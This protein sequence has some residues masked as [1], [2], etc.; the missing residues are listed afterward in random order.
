VPLRQLGLHL[1]EL[2]GLLA[3]RAPY[4]Q[5]SSTRSRAGSAGIWTTVMHGR[6]PVLFILKVWLHFQVYEI[7]RVLPTSFAPFTGLFYARIIRFWPER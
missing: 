5:R 4:P 1:G 6:T 7:S 3:A 2:S